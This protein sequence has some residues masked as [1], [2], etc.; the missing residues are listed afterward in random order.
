M[1]WRLTSGRN[2]GR[3]F[4]LVEI[5]VVVVII[6]ILAAIAVPEIKRVQQRARCTAFINDLRVFSET[7]QRYCNENGNFP[8]ESGTGVVPA[9]MA[10]YLR[11]TNW[12]RATPIGGNYDWDSGVVA[13]NGKTPVAMISVRPSGS[14]LITL[15]SQD[16]LYID[17][18]IDDGNLATGSFCVTYPTCVS[19]ILQN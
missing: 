4:T 9:G 14:N 6:G 19:Y 2:R 3:G 5:M 15:S 13:P 12:T 16:L 11:S 18:K 8:A 1:K 17:Q 7:Y 10:P